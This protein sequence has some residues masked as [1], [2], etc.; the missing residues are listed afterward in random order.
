MT[1]GALIDGQN[2]RCTRNTVRHMLTL[3]RQSVLLGYQYCEL[4]DKQTVETETVLNVCAA[5]YE[6][7][8]LYLQANLHN[9]P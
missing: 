9:P 2:N 4:R 6:C 3:G 7:V 5:R 8:D 1:E